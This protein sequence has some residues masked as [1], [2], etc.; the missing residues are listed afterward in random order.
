MSEK[1]ENNITTSDHH[2]DLA[3][4]K[5]ELSTNEP[6]SLRKAMKGNG[7]VLWWCFFFALSAIGW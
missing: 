4:A 5:S 7:T 3:V 6:L 2:E 1:H